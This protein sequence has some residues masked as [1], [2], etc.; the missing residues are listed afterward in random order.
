MHGIHDGVPFNTVRTFLPLESY[1]RLVRVEFD[2]IY[3]LIA[4]RDVWTE[5]IIIVRV[6]SVTRHLRIYKP[7]CSTKLRTDYRN[8]IPR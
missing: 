6:L 4:A 2:I 8:L 7:H 1:S 5:S 3:I